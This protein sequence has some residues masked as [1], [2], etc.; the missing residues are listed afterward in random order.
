MLKRNQGTIKD[1]RTK[2]NKFAK[3]EEKLKEDMKAEQAENL[4]KQMEAGKTANA[5]AATPAADVTESK[6]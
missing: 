6:Q 5:E 4:R 2:M 3:D 1:A